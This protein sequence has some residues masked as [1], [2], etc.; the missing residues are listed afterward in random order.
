MANRADSGTP[1]KPQRGFPWRLWMYAILMTAGTGAGGYFAWKYRADAN[2]SSE[3]WAKC[4]LEQGPIKKA[5]DEAKAKAGTCDTALSAS[6][7][8]AQQLETQLG[9]FSKNLNASKDELEKLR[10]QKA[11]ADKRMAAIEDIQKQFAKMIDTGQLKISARRGELVIS[12][13]AEVLFP[14][15]SAELSK[16]GEY[17]VVEV[18]AVLK[19]FPERRYLV[20]GHTDN[21]DFAKT[22]AGTPA[23]PTCAPADNWQ[24][25]TERALTVTRVLITAGMDPKNVIP[26]GAGDHDPVASN[27]SA[28]GRAKN[29]R[30]EIALLPAI[31]ELPPLPAGIADEAAG[32]GAK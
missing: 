14:S 30:I 10:A 4:S 8:K 2:T 20:V 17:A 1:V 6:T 13:P 5:I 11:E 12:L 23:V 29:R 32:S 18:A 31:N 16:T 24:L 21:Q 15:G 9:E 7:Q 28:D 25:S 22:K 27:A 19:K 26:A 3:A